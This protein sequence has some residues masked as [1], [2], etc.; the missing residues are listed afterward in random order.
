[1]QLI[2]KKASHRNQI[3]TNV[4]FHWTKEFKMIREIEDIPGVYD[5][6]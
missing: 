4:F 2:T 3:R 1:M 5:H 6:A